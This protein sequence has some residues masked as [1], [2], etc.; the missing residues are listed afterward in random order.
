VPALLLLLTGCSQSALLEKFASPEDQALAKN[1]VELL[2]QHRF[3]ELEKAMDPS[4]QGPELH[5]ALVKMATVVPAEKPASVTLIGAHRR[6]STDSSGG[7]VTFEYG[8]HDKWVLVGVAFKRQG[9]HTT[10]T[11]FHVTPQSAAYEEQNKFTLAGKSPIQYAVLALVVILPLLTL[12]ALVVCITTKFAGRK[13]P[14]V[15]FILFGVGKFAVNWTTGECDFSQVYIQLFSASASAVPPG[16]WIL[17][18]SFPLGAVLFFLRR[19]KLM[20]PAAQTNGVL[21][22]VTAPSDAT[23]ELTEVNR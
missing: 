23:I 1:C 10:V 15:L 17:A 3:D 22:D 5:N 19:K 13:W 20:A 7:D 11:G 16:P 8:F 21:V 12:Y 6:I 2:Q 14:W 18:V 9:S 4:L